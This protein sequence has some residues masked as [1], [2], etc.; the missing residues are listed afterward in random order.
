MGRNAQEAPLDAADRR[1]LRELQKDGR[2]TMAELSTKVGLSATPCWRRIRSLERRNV[3]EGYGCRLNMRAVGFE[4]EA[5]VQVT[6]ENHGAANVAEFIGAISKI[7]NIIAGFAVAGG[8][9]ALLHVTAAT[10]S[11]LQDILLVQLAK[12]PGVTHLQSSLILKHLGQAGFL[13]V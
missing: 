7:P 8:F 12:V 11:D 2:I 10:T 1:I 13:P 9:D 6:L 3:I 4:I 5:L